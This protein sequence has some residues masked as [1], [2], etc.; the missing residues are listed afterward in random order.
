MNQN[1]GQTRIAHGQRND[2]KVHGIIDH[3]FQNFGVVR[4]LDVHA[5]AGI[6]LLK[7][8]ENLGQNVKARSLVGADH[9][10][11]A[12]YALGF[13]DRGQ[14]GFARGHCLFRKFLEELAR[15]RDGNLSAGSV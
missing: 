7:L 6:L 3:G 12:R 11:A 4:T 8:S 1:H 14:H 5:N 13:G 9:N 2:A 15:C 10:L